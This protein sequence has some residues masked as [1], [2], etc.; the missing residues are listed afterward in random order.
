MNEDFET[1]TGKIASV[2]KTV[3]TAAESTSTGSAILGA[4]AT[5]AA[6]AVSTPV[7]AAVAAPIVVCGAILGFF[8]D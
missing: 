8:S 3:G 4:V 7:V 5:G 1:E 2:L 6:V